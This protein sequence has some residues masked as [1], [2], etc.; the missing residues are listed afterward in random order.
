MNLHSALIRQLGWLSLASALNLASFS[1]AG[2]AENRVLW[3]IGKPDRDF[4][5][6]ALAPRDHAKFKH[7]GFF[8]VGRSSPRQDW[9]YAHPGPSDSWAG[10]RTHAF[11]IVFALQ[12]ANADG[13]GRLK[14]AFVDTHQGGPPHL[15]VEINGQKFERDLPSGGGDESIMGDPQHGKP[16]QWDIAFPASLLKAG[17]NEIRIVNTRGSWALYDA[18][19]LEAPAGLELGQVKPRTWISEAEVQPVLLREGDHAVQPLRL[20]VSH[21]ADDAEAVVRADGQEVGRLKLHQGTQTADIGLKPSES[22]HQ[23]KLEIVVGGQVVEAR[24]ITV[25]PPRLRELWLL[26]HSH[27]DIGYT[28]RQEDVI[29]I[30]IGNLEKAMQLAKESANNPPGMRFKW[31]PEAVWALDHFLQRATPDKRAEFLAAVKQGDVGVDALYGNML[32]ALCRPEEL[33]QCLAF[34]ARLSTLTGVPVQSASICDVPGYTWGIVSMMAQA[35]VKYFAIG[36]NYGDRVGTIHQW[37]NRPFYWK[38]PSGNEKLLCWV[39]DNYHFLGNLED[40]VRQ[41][42]ARLQK[43]GFPYDISFLFWVGSWP[44]GGVDNAPPD[45]QIAAKVKAWNEKYAAPKVIIGLTGEFFREFEKHNGAKL[46]VQSGDLTPYW[47]DGAGS[48]SKETALNRETADRLQQADFLWALLAPDRRPTGRFDAAWKN[49]LLYSEHT[50]GAWCSISKPDDAFTVDQWKV[51]RQFALD[52]SSQSKDLLRDALAVRPK[53]A[54][55]ETAF[56]V[57]NGTQWKR[58]GLVTVPAELQAIGNRVLDSRGGEVPSQR[59]ANGDLVFWAKDV[60]PFGAKRYQVGAGVASKKGQALASGNTLIS[61]KL[62]I[63]VNPESG[64]VQSLKRAGSARE[65]VDAKSP[66]GLNEYRYLLGTDATKALG[67][68]KPEIRV[69][70]AGPLVATLRVR[71]EA[72]GCV[73]LVREVRVVEGQDWVEFTDKVDRKLV[74]EKDAVHFGFGFNVPQGKL[75]IETPWAVVRPNLD[76]LPGSCFNWYTVQRWVDISN[77]EYGVL[78]A[79]LDAPLME[80]GG[81]TANLLGSVA[82]HEWMTNANDSQTIYSWAQNNHWHTNYKAEQPGETVFRFIVRPHEGGYSAAESAQFGLET[83]RPLIASAVEKTQPVPQ[84]LLQVSN[85]NVLVES[86]KLSA[87]GKSYIVRLWGFS[88]Q[89]VRAQLKWSQPVKQ[90]WLSDLTEEPLRALEGAVEV[91]AGGV[92]TL[93]AD[94]L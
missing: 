94:R 80:I 17:D 28:H 13:E 53:P 50:W 30:Q 40:H 31:N 81:L 22:A 24:S 34:G 44:N 12:K 37:D 49:V 69:V 56:D 19:S 60:P 87:D 3:E 74:R 64:A 52:A 32:T 51:K 78:W 29:G 79:P 6:F 73:K 55:S 39:V 45:E 93:R 15:R 43:N 89:A 58:A 33:A 26:P 8:I 76:Q 35:G 21:F 59:L 63:A 46:P 38:S 9:P 92:V 72:P 54:A 57:Y 2:A 47:E 68:G 67:N 41:Q 90:L 16:S 11:A 71:S 36:P 61:S 20:T 84:S 83:T 18:V 85:P 66:V 62:Q 1:P 88:N 5:E 23:A 4:A 86:L 48:T 91:P 77:P 25:E 42:T 65:W 10:T 70:E 7:D 82:Y 14:L 75:H 27:V